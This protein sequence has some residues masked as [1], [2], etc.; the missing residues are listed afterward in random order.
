MPKKYRLKGS[1]LCNRH[2]EED[3]DRPSKK[4]FCFG[5]CY[6]YEDVYV[7][8]LLC[9]KGGVAVFYCAKCIVLAKEQFTI[10]ENP[11]GTP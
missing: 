10:K 8:P 1:K 2:T 4:G 6:P 11:T 7:Y 9:D 5:M 3:I